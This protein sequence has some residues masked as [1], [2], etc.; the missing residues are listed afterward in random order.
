MVMSRGI[1]FALAMLMAAPLVAA[2]D[3]TLGVK[4]AQAQGASVRDIR[5]EGNKRV[6]PETV[7]SYLTFSVGDHYDPAKAD[8]SLKALFATGLFENVNIDLKGGGVVVITVVESPVINRVAFEG[9]KEVKDDSLKTEIQ[10]K[11][12]AVFTRAKVQADVQRI[13]DVYHRQGYYAVQV[14]AQTIELDHNRVDLVYVVKEGPETKVLAIHFIGNKAF[15]DSQLKDVVTTSETGLLSFLKSTDVYDPDRLNLDRE[16]LRRFYLKNGYADARVISGVADLAPDGKGFFI[17]FTVEEGQQYHF[18]AVNIESSLAA[19][20]PESL[21]GEVLTNTGNTFNAEL[22]DKSVEKMTIAVAERGYAFGQIRPRVERDPIGRAINVT[23]IVEQGP[24]V[25]IERIVVSGN[26]RTH[27]RVIR[28]EFRIAEGDAYNRLLVDQAKQRLQALGFFKTVKVE[29]EAGGAPD[30]VTLSVQVEEQA[31]GELSLAGGYSSAE[32]VVAEIGYTER[33]LLGKGQFLQIKLSGSLTGQEQF[34]LSWTEPRFMDQNLS[35][36]FDVF[37]KR[38]DLTQSNNYAGYMQDDLGASVRLGFGVV[39]HVWLNTHYT[40]DNRNITSVQENASMAVKQAVED[41]SVTN[42]STV[43]YS[44]IYDTRN[45]RQNPTQGL[46]L[47]LNQDLAGVGGDVNYL[48]T[49]GEARGYYP[50][51]D[52]VTL[53]GRAIG[54]T[55][56]GW[57]GQNVGVLD[58]FYKGAETIRGFAPLGIGA[59]DQTTGTTLGGT[60]FYAGT[61]EVR[62]P[63]PL[64]PQELGFSAAVFA[65]A[66]SVFGVDYPST[67]PTAGSTAHNPV[68]IQDGDTLRTSVGGSLLWNSPVGPLRFDYGVPLTKA[69]YDRVRNFNFGAATKF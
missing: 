69:E 10:L 67:C 44:L 17:T 54:G 21:R 15:S 47:A 36:G 53:V 62:F 24:R 11:E 32:S 16:M 35:F 43:G 28:R 51:Y 34:Q 27:D 14:D 61:V 19:I 57:N 1:C 31:T 37:A 7:R 46:Y 4:T 59:R 52:S 22:T 12:R 63:V 38:M 26:V 48:R 13:L 18:G 65:D 45:L 3:V 49:V 40:F 5:V 58:N 68:C 6:E 9:N 25:Y 33:N 56:T 8:A 23:Y 60:N 66:G 64:V 2:I 41:G 30:R 39:D 20:D 42:I 29:K 50:V 55:I